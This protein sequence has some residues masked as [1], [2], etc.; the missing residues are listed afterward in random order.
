[1]DEK[2]REDIQR[3]VDFL[4]E[5]AYSGNIGFME[6]FKFRQK[7]N[8]EQQKQFDDHVA[9][10][11]HKEAWDVV[12]KVTG[13]KLHKASGVNEEIS[14][15]ILPKS[16]AGQDGTDELANTYK[17]DTPGQSNVVNFKDFKKNLK[18]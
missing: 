10:K 6:V 7:A 18:K 13:V 14:P 11:R 2:T 4:N 1:M 9:N 16:G 15:D 8:K 17:K 5:A 12:H 3:Q